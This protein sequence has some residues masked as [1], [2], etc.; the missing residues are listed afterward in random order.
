MAEE[1]PL[2]LRSVNLSDSLT[3][4]WKNRGRQEGNTYLNTLSDEVK[5]QIFVKYRAD[6]EMFGYKVDDKF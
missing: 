5:N 4:P 6:F 1:W 2:F 3:L